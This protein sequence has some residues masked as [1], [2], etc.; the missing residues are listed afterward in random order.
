MLGVPRL[1]YL[2][3]VAEVD[4]VRLSVKHYR[5]GVH[6]PR[7]LSTE[8]YEV[9]VFWLLFILMLEYLLLYNKIPLGWDPH[10]N[11]VLNVPLIHI[12]IVKMPESK[13]RNI[14]K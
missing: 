3:F 4:N 14:L 6:Y 7:C 9:S 10:L 13:F 2:T 1:G 11:A 8:V 12:H 5:L